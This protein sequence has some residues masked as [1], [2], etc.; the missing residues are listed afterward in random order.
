[1]DAKHALGIGPVVLSTQHVVD[2]Y[3]DTAL[4]SGNRIDLRGRD[5]QARRRQQLGIEEVAVATDFRQQ[6]QVAA[7]GKVGAAEAG[8][9]DRIAYVQHLCRGAETVVAGVGTGRH[10]RHKG[11]VRGVTEPACL[12]KAHIGRLHV[13]RRSR[14]AAGGHAHRG[15][16]Q[17]VQAQALP[18][19]QV[20]IP[21]RA[22]IAEHR[23]MVE[24]TGLHLC[25][26]QLGVPVLQWRGRARGCIAG[27]LH[28]GD[29][30]RAKFRSA[31]P[32]LVH[33]TTEGHAQR[34]ALRAH[35]TGR[36][37]Q[38]AIQVQ[39][40][41]RAQHDRA[42]V[43]GHG[44]GATAIHGQR[45]TG[46]GRIQNRAA[47]DHH[48][49]IRRTVLQRIARLPVQRTADPDA[50]A[51]VQHALVATRGVLRGEAVAGHI[52]QRV[53]ADAI[54]QR[55]AADLVA[56]LVVAD[57]VEADAA[58]LCDQRTGHVDVA[59]AAQLD[60]LPGIDLHDRVA[61]DPYI[62]AQRIALRAQ[63][64]ACALPLGDRPATRVEGIQRCRPGVQA[65]ACGRCIGSGLA[66]AQP[67]HGR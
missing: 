22:K 52:Q 4:G 28:Q 39:A 42:A 1:M 60:R 38:R 37:P 30:T 3:R 15:I 45:L 23:K 6:P 13:Q 61:A 17:P 51:R 5:V 20:D 54:A 65:L 67:R 53:A 46:T 47:L 48:E 40:I 2:R 59:T 63:Q 55:G 10:R 26:R 7:A 18:H 9:I 36:R 29:C 14:R 33:P 27:L 35:A 49:G 12:R 19:A 31:R 24:A 50:A 41:G 32:A 62:S 56:L 64:H 21:L 16:A 43:A 57:I 25:R 44:A 8:Q 34:A 58:C 11:I 66:H